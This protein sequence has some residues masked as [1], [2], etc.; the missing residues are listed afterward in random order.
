MTLKELRESLQKCCD[1]AGTFISVDVSQVRQAGLRKSEPM[2]S[3]LITFFDEDQGQ[4][5]I[6]S[7]LLEVQYAE[8]EIKEQ[9]PWYQ[10]EGEE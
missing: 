7:G 10:K 3:I 2:I 4:E 5:I 9:T 6:A 1:D 8:P